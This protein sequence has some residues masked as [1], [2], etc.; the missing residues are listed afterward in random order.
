M[1]KRISW[2]QGEIMMQM[3]GALWVWEARIQATINKNFD[4]FLCLKKTKLFSK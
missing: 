3:C 4:L 2:F 1:D